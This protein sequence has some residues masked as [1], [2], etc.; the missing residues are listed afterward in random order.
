M[1]WHVQL[2]CCFGLSWHEHWRWQSSHVQAQI[3][4]SIITNKMYK[5]EGH[6]ENRRFNGKTFWRF[7]LKKIY[8]KSQLDQTNPWNTRPLNTSR[9]FD[10]CCA[11]YEIISLGPKRSIK[12]LFKRRLTSTWKYYIRAIFPY[13]KELNR[14]HEIIKNGPQWILTKIVL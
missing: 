12:Q 6:S 1:S 9:C 10:N 14:A 13:T 8:Y 11:G 7:Q 2:L 3:Q 5:N 4:N